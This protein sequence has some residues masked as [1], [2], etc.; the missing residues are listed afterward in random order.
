MT[1]TKTKRISTKMIV[2]LVILAVIIVVFEILSAGNLITPNNLRNILESTTTVTL[3]TIG[4]ALL[5]ISGQIDL[6]LGA[7]GTFGALVAATMLAN[8]MFW[9]IALIVG[10]AFGALFGLANAALV[11]ELKLPS[12]IVTLAMASI[13]NGLSAMMCS[14]AQITVKDPVILTLGGGRI[15]DYLPI[16]LVISLLLLLV[17]GIML[18]KTESGRKI[19]LVGANKEAAR[20]CGINP[21]RVTYLLF[22]NAGALAALCGILVGGKLKYVNTMCI[23][24]QQFSGITASI[25]GGISMGGG[26][27]GM[28]CALIGIL[29][30]NF[31][32]NGLT[33]AGL[34]S[35]WQDIFGGLL[36]IFAL[37][38]DFLVL[39]RRN[40]K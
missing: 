23:S 9:L 30:L 20:L 21:K 16:A 36:F 5:M 38:A 13:A 34:S 25:L 14:G 22:I 18:K 7:S 4:S 32:K 28:G 10:I 40:S 27:G 33:L 6:S 31:F 37:L 15:F 35:Y 19:Y 29:I 8:G 26:T 2:L 12:F 24:G 11:S 1:K 17:Y 39:A 3:L